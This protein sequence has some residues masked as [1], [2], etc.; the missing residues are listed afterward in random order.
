MCSVLCWKEFGGG[1]GG[2][3]SKPW[4]ASWCVCYSIA[5]CMVCVLACLTCTMAKRKGLDY[6]SE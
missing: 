6:K 2:G 1:G 3:G 5:F 4:E